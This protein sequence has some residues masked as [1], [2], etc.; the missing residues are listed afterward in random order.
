MFKFKLAV[1]TVLVTTLLAF[2]LIT[3]FVGNNTHVAA[4]PE[5]NTPYGAVLLQN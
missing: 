3:H 4:N 5:K 1:C 2:N